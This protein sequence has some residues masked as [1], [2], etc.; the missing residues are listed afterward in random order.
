MLTENLKSYRKL[1]GWTQ[2][3]MAAEFKEFN[4]SRDNIASYE[5]GIEQP[6]LA[7]ACKICDDIKVS[8]HTF[9]Y[10]EILNPKIAVTD[11]SNRVLELEAELTKAYKTIAQMQMEKM[12]VV[13][14]YLK[15]TVETKAAEDEPDK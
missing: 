13:S 2:E 8:L 6:S 3:K 11:N 1:K 10:E 9:L 4:L 14:S 5:R 15:D 12:Q 7:F